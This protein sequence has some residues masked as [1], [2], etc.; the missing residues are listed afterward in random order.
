[1]ESVKAIII[2]VIA[3]SVL[4]PDIYYGNDITGIYF[5]THDD[6]FG[7]ITFDK[8]DAIKI[9]RGEM[10]PYKYE[11]GTDESGTW[12]FRIENSKWLE[13]RFNYEKENYGL[14]YG[15][16]ENVN[17]ML[18]DFKHYLFSF[19]DQFIEVIARGFWF[20]K[21]EESLF[22]QPLQSEHPFS[23]LPEINSTIF[24]NEKIKYKVIFNPI[25]LEQL[26]NNS[27][28]CQQV[29]LE[30]STEFRG[31]YSIEY[32]LFLMQRQGKLISVLRSFYGKSIFEKN[33]IACIDDIKLLIEKE[34]FK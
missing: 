16:G 29:L 28:F 15:F 22:K 23:K 26:I 33:G 21:S 8:F 18:I 10:M 7:R 20:E 1:M 27:Q 4:S 19:H 13:E 34:I 6:Q 32:T 2:P 3:D 30:V 11:W 31:E 9:C 12:V 14:S 25:P 24:K 5:S 17:E